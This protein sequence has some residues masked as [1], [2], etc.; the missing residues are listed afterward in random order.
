MM[1]TEMLVE[2]MAPVTTVDITP[3]VTTVD[4]APGPEPKTWTVTFRTRGSTG[5]LAATAGALTTARLNIISAV[6]RSAGV[7]DTLEVSFDVVPLEGVQFSEKDAEKLAATVGQIMRGSIDMAVEIAELRK[8]FPVRATIDPKVDLDLGS[9]LSAG[10]KVAFVDRPGLVYN[11]T[12]TLGRHH[13]YTRA[14]SVLI[15]RGCLHASFRVV[16]STGKPP[17][18]PVV[19][20]ALRA[21]LLSTCSF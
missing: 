17:R 19:L 2:P 12:E 1:A 13:L 8:V 3:G 18:N 15:F 9:E 20:G 14:L 16:D 4:I 7:L 6:I 5:A 21:E 11:V 10:I